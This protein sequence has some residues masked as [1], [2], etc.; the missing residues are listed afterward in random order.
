[1]ENKVRKRLNTTTVSSQDAKR[2]KAKFP[3]NPIRDFQKIFQDK[4]P[5]VREIRTEMRRVK[6]IGIRWVQKKKQ[7]P[8]EEAE[9]TL[10]DIDNDEDE[11][12]N[13]DDPFMQAQSQEVDTPTANVGPASAS[14]PPFYV[15]IHENFRVKDTTRLQKPPCIPGVVDYTRI[16]EKLFEKYE[17]GIRGLSQD[18]CKISDWTL[19]KIMCEGLPLARNPDLFY[20]VCYRLWPTKGTQL[21]MSQVFPKLCALYDVDGVDNTILEPF[22]PRQ[23]GEMEPREHNLKNYF[24]NNLPLPTANTYAHAC[25][26]ECFKGITLDEIK[27]KLQVSQ[28][29]ISN[30]SVIV[31]ISKSIRLATDEYQMLTAFFLS[32]EKNVDFCGV[33]RERDTEKTCKEVYRLIL[34]KCVQNPTADQVKQE[35]TFKRPYSERYSTF[36]LSMHVLRKAKE[37]ERT[38]ETTERA[39]E[40]GLSV[41]KELAKVRKTNALKLCVGDHVPCAHL[42]PCG[43]DRPGCTC[44]RFCTSNCQCDI[45][46]SRRNPGC[47]CSPGN[48]KSERCHCV[49][50][51]WECEKGVCGNCDL[52]EL[53]DG[54][55]I[56]SNMDSLRLRPKPIIVQKS[57]IAGW[58]AF[59]GQSFVK[60]E[61]LGE[62]LGEIIS[63]SETER[64]GVLY[65]LS[66][67]YIFGIPGGGSIDAYRYGNEFRFVNH[68]Q[69]PTCY[70]KF[71]MNKEKVHALFYAARAIQSGEEL[72]FDY[73]YDKETRK[74]F[75]NTSAA[76][77][78]KMMCG[79]GVVEEMAEKKV[80]K[81]KAETKD[82]NKENRKPKK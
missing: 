14:G 57:V 58:G 7:L 70:V 27:E 4:T 72:T 67:S 80:E 3:V 45:N 82:C 59:A 74:R 35:N 44:G 71:I 32:D 47:N 29:D 53:A 34:E 62:Y 17:D 66:T 43:P 42:G 6:R 24:F 19:H 78:I 76:D 25:S 46:C 75:F 1:M 65:E 68:A 10:I 51:Q 11:D 18:F 22:K 16:C 39:M 13:E 54:R 60:D 48:C 50:A 64:R 52:G 63:E 37:V 30:Q 8:T 28:S 20:Y 69:K 9:E 41:E 23:K 5:S 36:K 79:D 15:P 33:V 2:P 49:A 55:N 31:H 21:E 77:R 12:E 61:L 38:R 26:E 73:K 81:K 56:C 40:E